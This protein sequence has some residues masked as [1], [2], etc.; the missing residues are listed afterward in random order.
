MENENIS[1][2]LISPDRHRM[3]SYETVWFMCG[4]SY[5]SIENFLSSDCIRGQ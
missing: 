3:F 4:F 5:R 1:T 2:I